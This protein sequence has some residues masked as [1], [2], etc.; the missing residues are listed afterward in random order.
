M[1]VD[2]RAARHTLSLRLPT[3]IDVLAFDPRLQRLCAAVADGTV[4]ELGR[5]FVGAHAHTVAVDPVTHR[6]YFAMQR[7]SGGATRLASHGAPRLAVHAL[8]SRRDPRLA[9]T[10]TKRPLAGPVD[11][12][13]LAPRSQR[14]YV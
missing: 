1:V 4:T 12:R 9:R 2:L 7:R 5:G 3:E 6:V 14:D 13:R 10:R 8:T 11:G